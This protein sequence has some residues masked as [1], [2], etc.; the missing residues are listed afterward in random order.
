M[1]VA[2]YSEEGRVYS[3]V[4]AWG[5]FKDWASPLIVSVTDAIALATYGLIEMPLALLTVT[6]ESSLT[7]IAQATLEQIKTQR[8]VVTG[9]IL[10]A[11]YPQ[12]GDTVTVRL[13]KYGLGVSGFGG[14]STMRV[15]AMSFDS[16]RNTQKVVLRET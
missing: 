11:P 2:G 3:R 10:K 15:Q 8:K 14:N 5:K 13:I 16:K 6:D 7:V 12:I 1:N 4:T 9:E